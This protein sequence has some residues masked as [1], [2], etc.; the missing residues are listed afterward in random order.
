M[1]KSFV[2]KVI[3]AYDDY[4]EGRNQDSFNYIDDKDSK[5]TL[6]Y[7]DNLGERVY[8]KPIVNEYYALG[9]CVPTLTLE[10]LIIYIDGT[11][12]DIDELRRKVGD[13]NY[14]EDD[15]GE[16]DEEV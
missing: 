13:Y 11:I 9:D 10:G 6:V 2:W 4:N 1:K 7:P 15:N 3:E 12:Y 16:G 14:F 5:Y 8:F